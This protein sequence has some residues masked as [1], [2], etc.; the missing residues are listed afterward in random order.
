MTVQ[1]GIFVDLPTPPAGTG[2]QPSTPPVRSSSS[3]TP[4]YAHQLETYLHAHDPT[5]RLPPGA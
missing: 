2:R 3:S 4:H 1:V 5:A